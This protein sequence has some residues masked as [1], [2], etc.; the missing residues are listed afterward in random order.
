M[1]GLPRKTR[2]AVLARDDFQCACCGKTVGGGCSWWSIQHRKARGVGGGNALS[3]LIALC[4]SATSDGCHLRA[5]RRGQDMLDGGFWVPSWDDP[6]L[7]PVAHF[8]YGLVLLTDD[9]KVIPFREAA[10]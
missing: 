9:G 4:G 8:R 1:T 10:A 5:E 3:N 2:D 6:A 7:V